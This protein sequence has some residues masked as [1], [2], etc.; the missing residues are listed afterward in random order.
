VTL[1]AALRAALGIRGEV[2]K[3]REILLWHNIRIHLDEVIKLGT[4]VEFEAVLSPSDDE[5]NA[6]ARLQQLCTAL[7][8]QPTDHLAPSYADLLGLTVGQTTA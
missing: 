3:R 5:P 6:M 2:R 7:A 4:F 8:I 1:K